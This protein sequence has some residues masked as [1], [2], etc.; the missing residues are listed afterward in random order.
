VAGLYAE[1]RVVAKS[2]DGLVVPEDAVN[3]TANP[4][5]A[6]RVAG[7][8]T[9][10]V[11]L[12]LG[13]RDPRMEQVQ[14]VSGVNEGDVLLRGAAQGIAPGTPVNIGQPKS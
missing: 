5:W 8:K 10:K 3:I 7:G 6:L 9:E 2:A 11:N 14:I 13:L 4:P 1:G 12:T